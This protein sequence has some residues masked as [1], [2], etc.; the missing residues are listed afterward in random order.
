MFVN[1]IDKIFNDFEAIRSDIEISIDKMKHELGEFI[2]HIVLYGAGS[3]GIAFLKYLNDVDI[4]PVCF[5][6]GKQEKWGTM[7]EGLNIISPE[8]ITEVVGKKALVIVTINTDGKRYCKSFEEA[9]RID[10]HCGV[11]KMLHEYGCDNVIDYTYFRRC[12]SLFHGDNYNLPSCSD[13]NMMLKNRECISSV[14]DLLEDDLSKET[15]EKIV[16]FRLID[17]SI[18]IPTLTQENQYFEPDMYSVHNNA[19]FVDCGAFNG[20]SLK[21][22]LKINGGFKKYYGI[23]PDRY[24]Y[25]LLNDFVNSLSENIRDKCDIYNVA[26]YDNCSEELIYSLKGPGSFMSD[27]GNELVRTRT[28]DDI[29]DSS[30]ATYIKMNIE[31]SERKALC[32]AENTIKFFKPMLAIAGYH[33]T[34]DL[35]E[36]P[37]LIK[38]FR[39]DYKIR[40]RSYMNHLSFVYYCE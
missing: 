20:I 33:K 37:I 34:W 19:C 21:T 2:D 1:C 16:K 10:G 15:Y 31:G 27:K 9:L 6:D 26:A 7:C 18:T 4:H 23:E 39:A 11:H 40:L 13:I 35:W 36:I 22:F 29:L 38:K 25:E 17:D 30:E 3:A 14:Y 12:H 5:A 8:T 24:N 32:G 28:I